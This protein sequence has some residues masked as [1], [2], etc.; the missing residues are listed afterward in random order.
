MARS[1][2]S[3]RF[4][5]ARRIGRRYGAKKSSMARIKK[6]IMKCNFPTKVKF[7]GLTERKVMFLTKNLEISLNA[8]AANGTIANDPVKS[9]YLCPMN[10]ENIATIRYTDN[11]AAFSNWD[12]FC[13]L[14]VY[15]KFQP[16]R[17]MFDG[18]D[19]G[20]Q[21]YPVS[22]TYTMNNVKQNVVAYDRANKRNKQVFTFNSNEA[23]TIYVPAPT[24]MDINSPVV[25]KSKTWWSL[26]DLNK[27]DDLLTASMDEDDDD[28]DCTD[29]KD[30]GDAINQDDY[31]HAG[32][33]SL[34]TTASKPVYYNVT[35][36]YKIALKG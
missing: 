25:H 20:K 12:K 30:L 7:M 21:I 10:A 4:R 35:I 19:A 17:N 29:D 1:Y 28:D 18:S 24:T 32:R 26:T 6:D 3:R 13:I 23:F 31:M 9:F 11:G 5:S 36:N 15:I 27:F 33:I 16:R 14:G 34:Q 8:Q 2:R 22:A